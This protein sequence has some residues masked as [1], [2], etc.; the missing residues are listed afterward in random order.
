M[1]RALS[2]D[3]RQLRDI[4]RLVARLGPGVAGTDSSVS[5]GDFLALWTVFR[6]VLPRE[7][8]RR[9]AADA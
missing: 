9:E 1:V 5:P 2:G 7:R 8:K 6:E 4:E 3:A